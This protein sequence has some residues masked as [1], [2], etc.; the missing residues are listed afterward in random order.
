MSK[1]QLGAFASVDAGLGLQLDVLPKLDVST[2]HLH[3][4]RKSSRSSADAGE[5]I[6]RLA[7]M[8]V[9]ITCLFAGFEG[10]SYAD[11]P[12]VKQTVGLVPVSTR[13]QRVSELKE[14]IDFGSLLKVEAIG[15]HIGFVP[16]EKESTDYEQ[17]L[18]VTRDVCDY[19]RRDGHTLFLETGQEPADV[20]LGFLQDVG[21]KNLFINFDPANMILYGCGEPIE[22]LQKVG[23]YVRG[24]H[25]KDAVWSDQPGE[26]WGTEVPVGEGDVDFSQF[27][28]VL[29]ELNYTGPLT[30]EREIPQEPERQIAEIDKATRRLRELMQAFDN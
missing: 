23:A 22:A 8:D 15:L 25:C 29:D 24:V 30:I 16:H 28:R 3:A 7:E 10:E 6:R 1:W 18:Q 9:E 11:I 12:T 17:L 4:P 21:S 27:L 13:P 14:I 26:T 19:G 5:I 2:I 20:L